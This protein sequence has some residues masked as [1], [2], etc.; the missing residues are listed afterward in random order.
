MDGITLNLLVLMAGATGAYLFFRWRHQRWL[1]DQVAAF[2]ANVREPL[3]YRSQDI[4][5]DEVAARAENAKQKLKLHGNQYISAAD[6]YCWV[7]RSDKDDATADFMAWADQRDLQAAEI[8]KAFRAL[9][10]TQMEQAGNPQGAGQLFGQ[11][12]MNGQ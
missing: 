12:K 5:D 4:E 1:D 9:K 8:R 2:W 6:V 11:Q 10:A 7:Y 3:C